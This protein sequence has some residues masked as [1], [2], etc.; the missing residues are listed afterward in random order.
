MP[1]PGATRAALGTTLPYMLAKFVFPLMQYEGWRGLTNAQAQ[2]KNEQHR[3]TLV[4]IQQCAP[5]GT[6]RNAT[7]HLD[8]IA[9]R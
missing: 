7:S 5:R 6:P 4:K 2:Q 3:A 8:I 9:C 1:E